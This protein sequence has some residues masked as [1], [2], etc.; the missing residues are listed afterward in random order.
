[1]YIAFFFLHSYYI[2][3]VKGFR[4]VHLYVLIEGEEA[5]LEKVFYH[6]CHL[7]VEKKEKQKG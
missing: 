5:K 3:R 6:Y 1:M 4:L 7:G 2:W